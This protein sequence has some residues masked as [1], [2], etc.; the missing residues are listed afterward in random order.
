VFGAFGGADV[1]KIQ[2]KN[3]P[4]QELLK[5][6][7]AF[8]DDERRAQ[9]TALNAAIQGLAQK[10]SQDFSKAQQDD[11]QEFSGEQSQKQREY[12]Q[13]E[14]DKNRT[15]QEDLT[16]LRTDENVRQLKETQQYVP[17]SDRG[18]IGKKNK[19]TGEFF[20]YAG[21]G[22]GSGGSGSGR[23]KD[24]EEEYYFE[25]YDKGSNKPVTQI[26]TRDQAIN[27]VSD[28]ITENKNNPEFQE[29]IERIIGGNAYGLNPLSEVSDQGIKL[30]IDRYWRKNTPY[31]DES[32]NPQY[33]QGQRVSDYRLTDFNEQDRVN[34]NE[35]I[36]NNIDASASDVY[37]FI[38]KYDPAIP[39]DIARDITKR[40]FEKVQGDPRRNQQWNDP[41]HIEKVNTRTV[42]TYIQN[43]QNID[44]LRDV[45]QRAKKYYPDSPADQRN[46]V[47]T[48]LKSI[49]MS[50]EQINMTLKK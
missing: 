4:A 35:F 15:H 23:G 9:M 49:G 19:V 6:Q 44:Q 21:Q 47:R 17:G 16:K 32:V 39:D 1:P 33:Q 11:Q 2:Y 24:K 26:K 40:E 18:L 20:P 31:V 36:S 48:Y 5:L 34:L 8:A 22:G 30:I 37:N 42:D 46:A 38:K 43:P 3:E 14:N 45:A 27:L 13:G 10:K 28:I 29:D 12:Y 50:E 25:V 41:Q 7:D